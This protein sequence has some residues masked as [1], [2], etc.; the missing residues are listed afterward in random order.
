MTCHLTFVT[1]DLKVPVRVTIV[2]GERQGLI[3]HQ[4]KENVSHLNFFYLLLP[5]G[6]LVSLEKLWL[7]RDLLVSVSRSTDLV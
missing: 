6:S 3:L 2:G 7:R 5:W 1:V 4:K